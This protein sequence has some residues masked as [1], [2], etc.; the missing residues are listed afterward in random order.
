MVSTVAVISDV[1]GMLWAL[2]R[3]L[4]EPAVSGADLVVVTG[5]HTWGPEPTAV[6]DRLVQLG[7]RVALIRGNADRELL[8]MSQGLDVGLADDPL[9]V[10]GAAQLGPGH[11]RLLE[12]M[13]QT[14]TLD[15]PGFGPVL[16]CHA[17]PR[18]DEEVVLVDSRVERWTEVLAD[19]PAH[20]RT[21]VCGHTHMPFTRL[22]DGRLI[23]NSG[24]VGLP[25]G[26][27]GAH[28]ALLNNGTVTL[29][30]TP[31]D[32]DA[33]IRETERSSTFPGITD[34]LAATFV[35]PASDL[36]A[37]ANFGPRDG[38]QPT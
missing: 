7:D 33:L 28:W 36:D 32:R 13:P 18:N 34:W 11:Q 8:A 25:Y 24:S 1:H 30:R 6:L 38:R 3:V 15:L 22:I 4:D 31:L 21:V 12:Q 17:T 14:L 9:S 10:W 23:V 26:Q 29:G 20:V 37:L 35:E 2:D 27:P 19:L 5:D 16:F